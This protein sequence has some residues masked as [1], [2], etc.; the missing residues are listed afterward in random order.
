M[1]SRA[2]SQLV[3]SWNPHHTPRNI[4][5]NMSDPDAL[6]AQVEQKRLARA[7]EEARRRK[8]D[9]ERRRLE[10]EEDERLLVEAAKAETAM[11]AKRA[12]AKRAEQEVL[13][14]MER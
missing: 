4:Q 2:E 5:H 6:P 11:K 10:D 3:A 12:E 7:A 1:R 14:S 9:E 8:E 13:A